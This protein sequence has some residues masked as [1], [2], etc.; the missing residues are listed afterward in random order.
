[1]R[2]PAGWFL[3]YVL[4][5]LLLLGAGVTLAVASLGLLESTRLLWSSSVLSVVAIVATAAS[6][7]LSRR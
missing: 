7:L 1:V 6:L 5:F 2:R 4:A 3:T